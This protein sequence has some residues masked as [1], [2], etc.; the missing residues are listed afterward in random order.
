MIN[1][2]HGGFIFTVVLGEERVESWVGDEGAVVEGIEV[3]IVG[4]HCY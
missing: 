4:T 2:L 3:I 1:M